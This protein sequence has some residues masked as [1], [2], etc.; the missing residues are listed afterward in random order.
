MKG[1][2]RVSHHSMRDQT[3]INEIGNDLQSL[4]IK[5]DKSVD[6]KI[7]NMDLSA[8]HSA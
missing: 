5:T 3:A 4:L 8:R 2:W 1:L 6:S 7:Q